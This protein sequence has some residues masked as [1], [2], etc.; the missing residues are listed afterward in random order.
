MP[1]GMLSQDEQN[2]LY[3]VAMA[4]ADVA[5]TNILPLFRSRNL[6]AEN[7][8]LV[9]YD[10][11]TVAD[12]S[13][14]NAMREILTLRRPKD[15]VLGEEYGTTEGTSGLTWV[16]DPIDGT[17]GFISGTPTWGVLIAVSDGNGPLFG[18]IDQPFIGERFI[19]GFGWA[20]YDGLHEKCT[21]ATRGTETL[22]SS[23]LFTTFPEVGTQRDQAGFQAVA[24]QVQLVRY[25]MDCYAY[26]LL[27]L[28][29]IDLVIEAGL[30]SYDIQAPIAVIQAAG[31][32]VTD[33][34]GRPAHNGGQALASAN[35]ACHRAALELLQ[36]F[37]DPS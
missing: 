17:R 31:G 24:N 10:P 12:Q 25:G 29:Q 5:R 1:A 36:P 35:P 23:T 4:L 6:L 16:L 8:L 20:N 7:K 13:A 15:A 37:A 14:E 26:A 27:A 18:V 32:L 11:V 21:L 9:G 28:G 19:G 30:N 2:D 3:S 22:A 34:Q 33:W